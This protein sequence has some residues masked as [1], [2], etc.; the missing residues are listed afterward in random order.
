[1]QVLDHLLRVTLSHQFGEH[2]WYN[3]CWTHRVHAWG[4]RRA[5]EPIPLSTH[6]CQGEE[7]QWQASQVHWQKFSVMQCSCYTAAL[8]SPWTCLKSS[9]LGQ[10][11]AVAMSRPKQNKWSWGA[12]TEQITCCLPSPLQAFLADLIT[13]IFKQYHNHRCQGN[14]NKSVMPSGSLWIQNLMQKENEVSCAI[15]HYHQRISSWEK[16][17]QRPVTTPALY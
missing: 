15:P 10:C 13:Y 12:L 5:R 6:T 4:W 14:K 2:R 16:S 8:A 1:M 3:H 7:E 9:F 11:R 17:A